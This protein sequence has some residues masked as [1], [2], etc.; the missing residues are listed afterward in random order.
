MHEFIAKTLFGL[1]EVLA[2]E[3]RLLG[4]QKVTAYN[5]AVGFYGDKRI[6]YRANYHL[7]TALKILVPL[8]EAEVRNEKDLY[9]YVRTVRWDKYM[10]MNDTLAVEVALQTNVFSHTQYVAQKIKDAVVDQFRDKFGVRPSVDLD[11]PTLRINA[12]INNTSLKLSRDSSGESLHR[13]GYRYKQGP[14]PLNEVLAAGLIKLSGWN[15]T[16]CLVDF[17]CGSGTIAIEAALSACGIPPG[18]L[19]MNYGFQKWRDY[20]PQTFNEI[21]REKGGIR[22]NKDILVYASDVSPEAV[23]LATR[24]AQNA[25]VSHAIHFQTCHFNDFTPPAPPGMVLIN[26]PYGERIIQDNLNVLYAQ[27][28]D[29][30]KKGFAGYEAWVLSG[31]AEAFKHIGL[32]PSMKKILYNGQL[33]CR[34]NRYTLYEGSKKVPKLPV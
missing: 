2:Q 27:I 11:Q 10:G 21:A 12:Y 14:A 32:R 26:P 20:E 25:G 30:F 6:L 33:E 1:E 18:D 9:D 8:G 31:N 22:E 34:F 4:A 19:R 5:R 15:G 16:D 17:M 7:R 13:R 28:G 3:L 23:T 24:H 29:K